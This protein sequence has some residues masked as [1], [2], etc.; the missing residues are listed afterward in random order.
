ML[1]EV[2]RIFC[3][4][5]GLMRI[6]GHV[7]TLLLIIIY[8]A[9][10]SLGLPD[11]L[12]GS[13]W[14]VIHKELGVAVGSAGFVSVVITCGTVIS[15]LISTRMIKKFGTGAVVTVSVFMT[16]L[17]LLGISLSNRF[18]FLCVLALPLG[19]GGG[20]IDAGLNNFVALHYKASHMSFLHAFWG[21]GACMSPIIMSG[22]LRSSF[23]WHGG[24]RIVS[25][26]QLVLAF[27]MLFS[28]PLW[29][30]A[31]ADAPAPEA[32]LPPSDGQPPVS[33]IRRKGVI[34]AMLCFV[35]YCAGEMSVGL[36]ASTYLVNVRNLD[37]ATAAA[38]GSVFFFGVMGGR[39]LS[40][41]AAMRV[42]PANLVRI[43]ILTAMCG[44]VLLL[45]PL[46]RYFQLAA[47][48]LI[49]VGAGPI[50]P[51]MLHV[52]PLRFG[53]DVSQQVIGYQMAAS[54]I[55]CSLMPPLFGLVAAK[56]GF[57]V[58][59]PFLMGCFLLLLVVFERLN[60]VA[61]PT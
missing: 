34:A 52:T 1:L 37:T 7:A 53:A 48:I 21:I 54:Y 31:A 22:A 43:G 20:A 11:S 50:F 55:G 40:G 16:A 51:N 10:I 41:V 60:S 61:S 36:W 44:A 45:L 30:R 59:P 42:K 57:S 23:G 35:I 6:G 3:R 38:W 18:L 28:L 9:F 29:R 8:L 33:A 15:S 17:A 13:A 14:P 26:I 2:D 32:V 56:V 47:L 27:C 5:A 12:L 46:P 19:L 4:P 58:L 24:Y 25:I 49:G 39:L